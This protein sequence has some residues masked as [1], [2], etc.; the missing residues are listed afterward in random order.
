MTSIPASANP[1]K[2]VNLRSSATISNI[3]LFHHCGCNA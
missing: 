3:K 2:T 1:P